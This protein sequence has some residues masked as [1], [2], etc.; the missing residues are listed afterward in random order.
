M[1]IVRGSTLFILT[2]VCNGLQGTPSLS[3]AEL[4][5]TQN[6]EREKNHCFY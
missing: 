6:G 4:L 3:G 1:V 2:D 5:L